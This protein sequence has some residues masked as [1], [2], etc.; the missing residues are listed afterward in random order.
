MA[1]PP[2]AM[3]LVRCI[4]LHRMTRQSF[5]EGP[6]GA[7]HAM[8][9]GND[10]IKSVFDP[11]AI[12]FGDDEGRE[13]FYGVAR[14]ARDLAK[15]LV[16]LEQGNCNKLAKKASAHGFEERPGR[17]EFERFWASEFDSNHQSFSAH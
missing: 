13:Q 17:L 3:V 16:I 7:R 1:E 8:A 4:G 14:V 15:N 11:G 2:G 12:G 6:N 9:V 5:S 10:V